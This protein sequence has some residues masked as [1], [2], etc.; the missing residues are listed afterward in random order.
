MEE[1]EEDAPIRVEPLIKSAPRAR[2]IY[3][4]DLPKNARKPEFWKRRPVLIIS[5][6]STLYGHFTALPMTTVKQN[7]NKWAYKINSPL[8]DQEAWVICNHIIS[9][10]CSRLHPNNN[11][12]PKLDSETFDTVM[13][14]A[15]EG[16]ATP[17]A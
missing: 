13:K 3:F 16:L 4:C 15:I 8:E 9:L 10:S 17:L 14:L 11:S 7:E 2:Q 12:I 5:R 6:T 1:Q